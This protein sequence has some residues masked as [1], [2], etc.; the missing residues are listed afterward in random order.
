MEPS[1]PLTYCIYTR[2][3][4]KKSKE[5]ELICLNGFIFGKYF[6]LVCKEADRG[7]HQ[8]GVK[9]DSALYQSVK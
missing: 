8:N 5:G 7:N 9:Q 4:D 3:R 2:V 1:S 6:R